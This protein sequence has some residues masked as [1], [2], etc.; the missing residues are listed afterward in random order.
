MPRDL[1]ISLTHACAF[2]SRYSKL[3]LH[4]VKVCDRL[5]RRVFHLNT[6]VCLNEIKFALA[7]EKKLDGSCSL[8]SNGISHPD[9]SPCYSFAQPPLQTGSWSFLHNLLI[10]TLNRTLS[11]A[12]MNHT[13]VVTKNLNFHVARR[14]DQFLYV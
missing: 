3:G 14:F 11:M 13:R 10:S 12:Q 2:A 9:C 8:I 6:C 7:I 5:S 4:D 1:E